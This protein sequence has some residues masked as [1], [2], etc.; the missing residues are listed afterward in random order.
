MKQNLFLTNLTYRIFST[1]P[2]VS[3]FAAN[4]TFANFNIVEEL[5]GGS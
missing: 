4:S 5:K 3:Y 1:Y 2:D